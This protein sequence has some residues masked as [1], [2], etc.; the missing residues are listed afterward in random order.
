MEVGCSERWFIASTMTLPHHRWP[1]VP[2]I[3][4]KVTSTCTDVS[5]RVSPYPQPQ[6]K[7]GA[8]ILYKYILL[9]WDAE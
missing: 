2:S 5:I 3:S 6:R 1:T 4:P 8:E 9:T 7:K